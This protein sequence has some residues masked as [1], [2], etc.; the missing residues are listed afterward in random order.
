[1]L[2]H[3]IIAFATLVAVTFKIFKSVTLDKEQLTGFGIFWWV[4]LIALLLIYVLIVLWITLV[5]FYF[6]GDLQW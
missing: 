6:T 1:M 5:A 4:F 3:A 2:W